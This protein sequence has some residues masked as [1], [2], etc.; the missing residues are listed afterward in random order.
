MNTPHTVPASLPVG[1]DP[2]HFDCGWRLVMCGP[3]TAY[4]DAD[5]V[6]RRWRWLHL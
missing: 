5:H 1:F 2:Y 4:I 6:A 3:M